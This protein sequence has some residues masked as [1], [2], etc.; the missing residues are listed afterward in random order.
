MPFFTP[1]KVAQAYIGPGAGIN[2]QL[3][4]YQ[5]QLAEQ[6]K[7]EIEAA[8]RNRAEQMT[9]LMDLNKVMADSKLGTGTA[10]DEAHNQRSQKF[11]SKWT[12]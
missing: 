6:K 7:L 4:L 1:E 11:Y 2:D 9:A 5:A 3:K 10:L 8:K 12:L